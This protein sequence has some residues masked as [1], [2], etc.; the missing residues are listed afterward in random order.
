MAGYSERVA[1]DGFAGAD[2]AC[3]QN[4]WMMYAVY[5]PTND[6][7]KYPTPS[8]HT[9]YRASSDH[10][11][12]LNILLAD[13]SVRF[14]GENIEHILDATANTSYPAAHG[15]G[16]LWVTG[17]CGWTAISP[18]RTRC[19]IADGVVAAAQPQER[20]IGR[21][22]VRR[23]ARTAWP[24]GGSRGTSVLHRRRMIG[25]SLAA[26]MS[27]VAARSRAWTVPASSP[28]AD[29]F[30]PPGEAAPG[31]AGGRPGPEPPRAGFQSA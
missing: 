11:G 28:S 29:S 21:R 20:R 24:G 30:P 17:G 19:Q 31:S 18:T 10:T 22:R 23:T 16:C 8:V 14:L 5:P 15:A 1:G 3:C 2:V 4:W 12:G 6:M 9:D 7:R 25:S 13:G 26:V 27:L